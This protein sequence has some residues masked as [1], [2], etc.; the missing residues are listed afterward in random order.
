MVL[1]TGGGRGYNRAKEKIWGSEEEQK[2]VPG[3]KPVRALPQ[4]PKKKAE[5]K[6]ISFDDN[7]IVDFS[8]PSSFSSDQEL[9]SQDNFESAI[10]ETETEP[11]R[12]EP[13]GSTQDD[14]EA[15]SDE[16]E[17]VRKEIAQ[18]EKKLKEVK[19][20]QHVLSYV[21][22]YV[23]G[24]RPVQYVKNSRLGQWVGGY[25]RGNDQPL[26]QAQDDRDQKDGDLVVGDLPKVKKKKL[27]YAKRPKN[28]FKRKR[29]KKPFESFIEI[30]KDAEQQRAEI[31]KVTK[32]Q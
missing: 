13:S 25:W 26:R 5:I 29:K 17:D 11:L 32:E 28:R 22:D 4:R 24:S 21:G 7:E 20:S 19:G 16:E 30:S 12:Y 31:Q 2:K 9:D 15:T 23:G 8:A 1:N 3:K 14:R 27:S 6:E 18:A 10:S